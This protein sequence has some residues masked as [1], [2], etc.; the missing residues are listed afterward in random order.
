MSMTK[1]SDGTKSTDGKI[2]VLFLIDQLMLGGSELQLLALMKGLDRR[3]YAV[4]F[5]HFRPNMPDIGELNLRQTTVRCG[6]RARRYDAR[7]FWRLISLIHNKEIHIVYTVLS[8]ADI[9]GRL[10]GLIARVPA[11][12]CRKGTIR[13]G[14]D[15][16]NLEMFFDRL[17]VRYTS[18]VIANS[19]AGMEE[20]ISSGRARREESAIIYNGTDISRFRPRDQAAAADAR[21]LLGIDPDAFVVGGV[22]RLVAEKRWDLVVETMAWLKTRRREKT[23]CVIVGDGEMFPVIREAILRLRLKDEVLLLG[24]RRDVP[25]VMACMDVVVLTSEREGVPN[26]LCE[27]MA[28][29][30]PVIAMDAGAVREVIVDGECGLVIAPNERRAL[31]E[32]ICTLLQHRDLCKLWGTAGRKLVAEKFS[33]ERMVTDTERVFDWVLDRTEL[34]PDHAGGGDRTDVDVTGPL[35]RHQSHPK[36]PRMLRRV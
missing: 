9:W 30:K 21:S 32:A 11:M 29:E 12:V 33:L 10:A 19:R 14:G 22:G 4:Y 5:C 26:V 3:K 34:S 17:L 28:M 31:G 27:A 6:E 20:L 13:P 25:D 24:H 36:Y 1:Q 8:T 18:C 16:G 2:R 7:F 15:R 35:A 23:R